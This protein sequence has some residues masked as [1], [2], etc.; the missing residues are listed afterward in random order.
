MYS[1]HTRQNGKPFPSRGDNHLSFTWDI[2]DSANA[3]GPREKVKRTS[4]MLTVAASPRLFVRGRLEIIQG[5]ESSD[6]IEN[7]KTLQ[8]TCSN[9]Q[10]D[11][12]LEPDPLEFLHQSL[13]EDSKK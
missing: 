11:L 1:R 8:T 12:H 10:E 6:L 9:I 5:I 13:R 7:L 2:D 3:Q 4:K